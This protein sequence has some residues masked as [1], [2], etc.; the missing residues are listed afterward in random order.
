MA[1]QKATQ[2]PSARNALDNATQSWLAVVRAYNLCD[3]VMSA[4]LADIG[5]RLG[6]HEVLV[7]LLTAP[8]I[9]QQELAVRCFVAK[10]G[11]SMLVARMEQQGLLAREA[12]AVDARLK[13]LS[14]TPG[15]MALAQQAQQ[16][17]LAVVAAMAAQVSAAELAQVQDV[18]LRVAVQLEALR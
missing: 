9:T 17:Q 14:L 16:I 8:G 11:V 2:K 6:E 1:T 4:R 10:S 5:L 18:M 7:N 13:R 15:G 3:A 12:D